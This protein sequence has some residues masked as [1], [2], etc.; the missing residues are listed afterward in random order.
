MA[1]IRSDKALLYHPK[2]THLKV[3]LKVD[4][5]VVIGR[6]HRLWWWCLDYALDGDLRKQE[7][8]VI[9]DA[10]SIP[11]L[12][13]IRAGFIDSRPYRRI[14]DWWDNQGN[15]LKLRFR[16]H[17]EKWMQIRDS[18]ESKSHMSTH[19][20]VTTGKPV[21]VDLHTDVRT[22]QTDV[23][24][25]NIKKR[26]ASLSAT[27]LAGNGQK[28]AIAKIDNDDA[29]EFSHEEFLQV[30]W[31]KSELPTNKFEW[32]HLERSLDKD[33]QVMSKFRERKVLAQ[34]WR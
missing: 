28:T 1:W 23:R 33:E 8:K 19:M 20:S 17:P 4:T 24:T 12:A 29:P 5:D 3:L 14:H 31:R 13:L 18:Y 27:P 26:A 30:G 7:G 2:T 21:D 32:Q 22:L 10:C 11:L 16:D 34:K 15:Y 9:E 6:L 25:S